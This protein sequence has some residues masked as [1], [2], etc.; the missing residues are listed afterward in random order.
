MILKYRQSMKALMLTSVV[1]G[2]IAGIFSP[3]YY[4]I[5]SAT[6]FTFWIPWVA[7]GTGNL[8]AGIVLMLGALLVGT[9]TAC[10]VGYPEETAA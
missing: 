2:L 6:A 7:G 1:V 4:V 10:F 9:V 8:I 3:T 5:T